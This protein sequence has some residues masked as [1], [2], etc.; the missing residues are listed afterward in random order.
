MLH[1][2]SKACCAW[3]DFL[4]LPWTAQIYKNDPNWVPNL[5]SED[6]KL[7]NPAVHPFHQHAEVELFVAYAER[8]NER[9]EGRKNAVGRIAA[10]VN[11][12]HNEF[13]STGGGPA[14]GGKDQT[15]FFGFFECINDREVSG[16]LFQSAA[17]WLKSK[18]MKLMRGPMNFSTNET[19]GLLI[20]GFDSPPVVMMTY[21][22]P[23]YLELM[24]SA[25]LVKAKDLYAWYLSSDIEI[26]DKMVRVAER[27]KSH[28][29]IVVRPA[30]MRRLDKE[31]DIIKEVYN[32]AWSDNWGFVPM[33]DA[34]FR[35]MAKD[36][37]KV[38]DPSLLLI[39]EVNGQPAGFSLALPDLNQALRHVNGRLFPF[40]IFKFLWYARRINGAR[41]VTMGIIPEYRKRGI[42]VIFYI[43]SI[44]NAKAKG[45][46][47]GE[48]S[49]ILEDNVLMN[50][51]IESL[52]AR[53]YKKYRIYEKP[54]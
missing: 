37:G 15:G 25:G 49:W 17:D 54:L 9:T 35:F 53:L 22:P 28:H 36:M 30:D 8:K 11:H 33:T 48:L 44:R 14:S 7:L 31:V 20:E 21:N 23:Y 27:V 29:N 52:G 47:W 24:D 10:I 50:R 4:L 2:V 34:E 5:I 46:K 13:Y 42:D 43:E 26:P 12:K 6:K 38:I 40:G 3:T 19:C 32:K 41:V 39:A 18:G 51:T 1:I 16:R 45:Y